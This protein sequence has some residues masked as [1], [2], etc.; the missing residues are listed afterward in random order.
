[1]SKNEDLRPV[2]MRGGRAF[3]FYNKKG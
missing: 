2:G 1:L 3:L